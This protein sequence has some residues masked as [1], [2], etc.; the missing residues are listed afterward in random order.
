LGY[1]GY[2]YGVSGKPRQA[3]KILT[4][5]EKRS[6]QAYLSPYALALIH[7]GLGHKEQALQSLVKTFEDRNEMFGFVKASPEFDDLRSEEEFEA[8][9]QRSKLTATA[10]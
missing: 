9:L 6:E 1:L 5:L 10:P 7:T 3:L 4:G 8:L 2:A